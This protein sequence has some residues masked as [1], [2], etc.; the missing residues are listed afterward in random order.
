MPVSFYIHKLK[1]VQTSYTNAPIKC[2]L[3]STK[4]SRMLSINIKSSIDQ[5]CKLMF[6]KKYQEMCYGKC[7]C[8]N[9]PKDAQEMVGMK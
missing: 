7:G 9:I 2:K 3:C 1:V 8:A 6:H 5:S 4:T